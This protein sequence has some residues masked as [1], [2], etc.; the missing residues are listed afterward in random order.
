MFLLY[1]HLC[2]QSAGNWFVR[3]ALSPYT[4]TTRGLGNAVLAVFG[5]FLVIYRM[6]SKIVCWT[7]YSGSQ[8]SVEQITRSNFTLRNLRTDIQVHATTFLR[9][10]RCRRKYS[11]SVNYGRWQHCTE[12]I[13][14][15]VITI[16]VK[17]HFVTF[18]WDTNDTLVLG[19]IEGNITI[20]L[21]GMS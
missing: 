7:Q 11:F 9:S 15:A 8:G 18:P 5:T 2:W 19:N 3:R 17:K 10:I 4:H 16:V 12:S 13:F 21:R 6:S 20:C 1:F 14:T